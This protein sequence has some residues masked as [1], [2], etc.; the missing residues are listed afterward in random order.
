MGNIII[1]DYEKQSAHEHNR[2]QVWH[3]EHVNTIKVNI[4]KMIMVKEL[5][6]KCNVHVDGSQYVY[7]H[8]INCS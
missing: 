3:N 6:C 7:T 8:Y 4:T 2:E 1:T 5:H